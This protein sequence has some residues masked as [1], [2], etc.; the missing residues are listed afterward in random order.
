MAMTDGK[1]TTSIDANGEP[2]TSEL[3]LRQ[4]RADD[5]ATDAVHEVILVS[6]ILGQVSID[7]LTL[8]P[9]AADGLDSILTRA[10]MRT[11][12]LLDLLREE[13]A[14]ASGRQAP[15]CSD[16]VTTPQTDVPDQPSTAKT[17]DDVLGMRAIA[18]AAHMD[19]L[20]A[21]AALERLTSLL[22]QGELDPHVEGDMDALACFAEGIIGQIGAVAE[23]LDTLTHRIRRTE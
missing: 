14:N 19:A 10:A 12:A 23:A 18:D 17:P 6:E 8:S 21:R 4:L 9:T 7:E 15:E 13:R 2:T 20:T 11:N 22:V 5:L 3:T 1:T 16:A